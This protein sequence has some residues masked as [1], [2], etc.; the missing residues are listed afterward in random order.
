MI[1]DKEWTTGDVFVDEWPAR[2][3]EKAATCQAEC[4]YISRE[5]IFGDELNQLGW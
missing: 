2:G 1:S 3:Q 4:E 5:E